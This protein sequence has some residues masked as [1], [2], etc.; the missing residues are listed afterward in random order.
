MSRTAVSPFIDAMYLSHGPC[1]VGSS[2]SSISRSVSR[3]SATIAASAR[4][5]LLISDG[6]MST[7]IF[8]ACGA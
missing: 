1:E 5:F 3:R 6:S 8:F 7:W 4:T 2:M